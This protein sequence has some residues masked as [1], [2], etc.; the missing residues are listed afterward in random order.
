LELAVAT[1][2]GF[3][4]VQEYLSGL[5]SLG[6]IG[7]SRHKSFWKVKTV[8]GVTSVVTYDD[9]INGTIPHVAYGGF[10]GSAAQSIPIIWKEAPLLSPIFLILAEAGGF[11]GFEQMIAHGGAHLTDPNMTIPV[12]DHTTNPPVMK[13]I[14]GAQVLRDLEQWLKNGFP[15]DPTVIP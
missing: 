5:A 14:A 9:F 3:Q 10:T 7:N 6:T 1:T 2:I 13:M 11:A 15:K 8:G 4:T 12:P